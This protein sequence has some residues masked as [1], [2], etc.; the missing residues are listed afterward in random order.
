MHATLAGPLAKYPGAHWVQAVWVAFRKVPGGH[1]SDALWL[2][3]GM[4]PG[5]ASRHAMPSEEAKAVGDGH[6]MQ[7]LPLGA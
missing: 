1:G 2:G 6:G 3:A 5:L 7:T 4:Y